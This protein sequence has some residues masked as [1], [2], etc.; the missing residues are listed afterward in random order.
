MKLYHYFYKITNTKNNKYYY[1]VHSTYNLNDN[2]MGSGVIIKK[3]IKTYGKKYLLKEIIKFFDTAED[4][5]NYEKSFLT[6]DIIN[7]P[8]CYN[9]VGGGNGFTINHYVSDE[10]KLKIS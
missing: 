10:V 7:N 4:M 2:Y 1:G 5:F 3:I 9:L 6:E 8:N